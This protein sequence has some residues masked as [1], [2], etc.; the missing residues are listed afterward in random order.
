MKVQRSDW[1]K[2]SVVLLVFVVG[3]I[4]SY[5]IMKPERRLPIYN[6]S[7]LDKRLVD[8][9]LQG[10]G[11]NHRVLPF[12]LVNQYGDTITQDALNGKIYIADFF[13]TTCPGICKDMAREKR[14]L[15][16]G[17]KDDPDFVIVSHSV[18]PEMDSVPVMR[19]YAEMQGAI[20]GKWQ[21]LTGD[22]PQIY[23]L[24]RKSYFAI[25]DEGGNGDE[26]DF[27]HTENFV[28]VDPSKRIRGFYDGTS[29]EDVDRLIEDIYILKKD[30]KK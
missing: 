6:P 17:F 21:L 7:E 25:F 15:Q 22:K 27:I 2:I 26:S 13:F 3:L 5:Y 28:L 24:A 14:R 11:R 19:E 4:S 12:K 16:E 23:E 10:K 8:P 18:T 1:L 9:Q 30:L 20:Q 29:K